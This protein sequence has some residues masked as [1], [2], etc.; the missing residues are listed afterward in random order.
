MR[1]SAAFTTFPD[2]VLHRGL[3]ELGFGEW[4]LELRV[5]GLEIAW[6]VGLRHYTQPNFDFQL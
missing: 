2:G 1:R 3:V 6:S 4:P 5:L